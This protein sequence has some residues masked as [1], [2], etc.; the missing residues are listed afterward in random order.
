MEGE[1][2]TLISFGLG[3]QTFAFDSLKVRNILP[4][5][6][7]V[8]RV[9]NTREFIL[10]VIN[11]HGNIVPVTDMRK[12]MALEEVERTKDTSIIIVSPEDK[13]ESQFGILVDL[14]K[15][16]FEVPSE[17][18]KP[19]AF[20]NRMGLIESFEGTVQEK[21]EFVHLIDLKHVLSQIESKN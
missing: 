15:E 5:E 7:N 19:A 18:I 9:P 12:I 17:K 21:E 11:L 14:V 10:G 6:G 20:E 8:T 3:E 1:F 4:Y 2:K 16:V 13:Q